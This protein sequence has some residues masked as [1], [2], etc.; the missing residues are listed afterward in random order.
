MPI[1]SS[2]QLWGSE[3]YVPELQV[4]SKDSRFGLTLVFDIWSLFAL[5][6]S[7][8][9]VMGDDYVP[10]SLPEKRFY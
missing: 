8:T 4:P 7:T 9:V 5:L 2:F 10:T 3:D 1:P 6:D